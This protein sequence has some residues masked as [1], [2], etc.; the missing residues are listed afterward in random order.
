M[1]FIRVEIFFPLRGAAEFIFFAT[2][3]RNIICSST[4]TVFLSAFRIFFS[5]HVRDRKFFSI[6]FVDKYFFPK[7]PIAP[8]PLQVKWMIPCHTNMNKMI[9]PNKGILF[10]IASAGICGRIYLLKKHYNRGGKKWFNNQF[11]IRNY[12]R[13]I[14]CQY[15]WSRSRVAL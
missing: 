11:Y 13:Y 12:K 9:R 4:K 1:V 7:T 6:N 15:I 3:C 8:T 10:I 14:Y 2:S 5:V